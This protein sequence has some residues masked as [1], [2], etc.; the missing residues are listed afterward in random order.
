[1]RL[2]DL[3]PFGEH[4]GAVEVNKTFIGQ[5]RSIKPKDGKKGRGYHH[6]HKVLALVDR[7]TGQAH[8]MLVNALKAATLAPSSIKT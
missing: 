3:E 5:D 6:K 1:M 7:N 8:T 4:S 2:G